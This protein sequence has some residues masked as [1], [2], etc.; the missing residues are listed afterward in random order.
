MSHYEV[1]QKVDGRN[2][3]VQV[4]MGQWYSDR[5]L[6]SNSL[7]SYNKALEIQPENRQAMHDRGTFEDRALYV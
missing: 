5:G 2:V 1:A 4:R 7:D 3:D 6:L